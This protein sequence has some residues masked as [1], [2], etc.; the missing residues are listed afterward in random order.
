MMIGISS[1]AY[2]WASGGIPNQEKPEQI[3]TPIKLAEKALEFG[4]KVIQFGDNMPL[5]I[6]SQ[7]EIY[8]LKNFCED[9]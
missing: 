2:S 3:L 5:D 6:C 4:L 7:S 9:A 1:Y 8:S